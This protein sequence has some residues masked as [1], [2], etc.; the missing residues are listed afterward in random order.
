MTRTLMYR[1]YWERVNAKLLNRRSGVKA[2]WSA[3]RPPPQ[4]IDYWDW[5]PA[6]LPEKMVFAALIR[7]QVTFFFSF[8][9]GDFPFTED[10]VE[11]YR[12]DFILP[13]YKI[14]IEISG[15]YWHSRPGMFEFDSAKFALYIAAGWQVV[16]FTDL[17]V[18]TDVEAA[19]DSVPQLVNPAV[20]NGGFFVGDRPFNPKASITGRMRRYP[21]VVGTSFKRRIRGPV[22]VKGTW[23][24]SRKATKIQPP[25]ERIFTQRDFDDE[26]VKELQEFGEEW[27]VWLDGLGDYFTTFPGQKTIFPDLWELYNKWKNWWDRFTTS[28]P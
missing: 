1:R 16:I 24:G 10:K 27:R 6:T 13:D 28:Q 15:I 11:R 21:K 3:R 12:P 8:Y 9:W 26:Y 18:L 17:E 19:L 14:I 4:F 5:V 20:K 7:R 25:L 22:G 23:Q 2:A